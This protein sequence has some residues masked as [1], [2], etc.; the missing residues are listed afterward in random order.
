MRGNKSP[1]P[2]V[3]PSYGVLNRRNF[4]EIIKRYEEKRPLPS[5]QAKNLLAARKNPRVVCLSKM[6]F[7]GPKPVRIPTKLE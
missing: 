1:T 3:F 7:Y 4:N 5:S 6:L 2:P